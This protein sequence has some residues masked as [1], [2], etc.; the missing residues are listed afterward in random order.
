MQRLKLWQAATLAVLA[1]GA[2]IGIIWRTY[3][4]TQVTPPMP[5][6]FTGTMPGA[7]PKH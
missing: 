1:L 5:A 6:P 7:P 3:A 2:A 4:Q